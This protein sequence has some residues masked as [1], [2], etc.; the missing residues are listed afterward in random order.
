MRFHRLLSLA[1]V[2][3]FAAASFAVEPKAELLWPKGAPGANGDGPED[4][5]TLT[6]YLP[7]PTKTVGTAVVVC[8]GG[9]YGGLASDHEGRQIAEWFN[10]F[11][12][13]GFVLEYRHRGRG[14]GHPTP[15][16]DVQRALRT[17]RAGAK[18]WRI[19]PHKIGIIGFSA[20][21]HL[22]STAGTHFDNGDPMAIDPIETV[23]CRPDFMILC[24]PVIALGE[25]F[26]H[27]GS[28]ENLLGRNPSEDLI[29][30]LSNEKQV[31]KDT[32]P[33]FLFTS[34]DD[35]VVPSEN[36]VRFY[37]ALQREKVPAELHIYR[38]SPHGVG[39]ARN[40]PG[41]ENWPEACKTWMGGL[42]LLEATGAAK[43]SSGK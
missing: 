39:L 38:S 32:P 6:A 18:D 26:T 23:G 3:T 37:L 43:P 42:H 34:D 13:A 17:V 29:E 8:P 16:Q 20:G 10:T 11:G 15:M 28:Q 36:S 24:Y 7:D 35:D 41:S 1:F 4:K 40:L 21:G 27:R 12:V 25:P 30:N 9:G 5:P 19:N 14:Y 22:A 31:T 33:T 2:L